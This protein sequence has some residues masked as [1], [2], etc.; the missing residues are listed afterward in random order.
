[1][2][3]I[4]SVTSCLDNLICGAFFVLVWF[5]GIPERNL[6]R[7]WHSEC[8]RNS[9]EHMGAEAGVQALPN[10]REERLRDSCAK[11]SVTG[12]PGQPTPQVACLPAL[13]GQRH[14]GLP[15]L[16]VNC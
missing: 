12:R 7:N 13:T 3:F 9:Q 15:L 5:L 8:K 14:L 10:R 4:L 1:M 11:E 16:S 6:E 2:Y